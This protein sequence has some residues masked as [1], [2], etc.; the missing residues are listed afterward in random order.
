LSGEDLRA[1]ELRNWESP[2]PSLGLLASYP[3]PAPGG[4]DLYPVPGSPD[5]TVTAN[6]RTWLFHRDKRAFTPHPQLADLE[7]IKSIATHPTTGQTVFLQADPGGWWT[8]TIRFLKP[9]DTLLQPGERLYKARWA[10]GSR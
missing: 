6:S 2:G 8:G 9:E 4:H 1:Y 7:H 3:L 5:L 10:E